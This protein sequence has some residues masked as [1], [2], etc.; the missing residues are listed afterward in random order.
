VRYDLGDPIFHTIADSRSIPGNDV[1]CI[2]EDRAGFLWIGTHDGAVRYDGYTFRLFRH[3]VH[4]PRSLLGNRIRAIRGGRD[5]RVWI[6][7]EDSGVSIFDPAKG[8]F[9]NLTARDSGLASDDIRDFA[10]GP[11]GQMWVSSTAGLDL[12]DEKTL[13]VSRV[14]PR[15]RGTD[16]AERGRPGPLLLD[17]RGDLWI[18]SAGGLAVRRRDGTI[19][20]AGKAAAGADSL[21][22]KPVYRLFEAKDGAIWIAVFGG[23]IARFDPLTGQVLF[24]DQG[25]PVRAYAFAQTEPATVWVGTSSD[26]IESRDAT[27][28][29]L[30]SRFTHD[31]SVPESIP[32]SRISSL[33]TD[34]SGIVWIGTTGSGLARY[35][36][37]DSAF[38]LL[39]YSPVRP[40]GLTNGEVECVFESSDGFL[41]V[42]THDT[43][44]DVFDS[45]RRVKGHRPGPDDGRSIDKARVGAITETP[46]GAIWMGTSGA[47]NRLD[48]KTGR[49]ERFAAEAFG[50]TTGRITTLVP[51]PDGQGIWTGSTSGLAFFDTR[52]HAAAPAEFEDGAKIT[53]TIFDIAL[54][55]GTLWAASAK[56]LAVLPRGAARFRLMNERQNTEGTFP[57][58]NPIDLLLDSKNKLWIGLASGLAR[59]SSFDGNTAR[60][61][62][63]APKLGL[64]N[65]RC[66][67]LLEDSSGRI[68]IEDDLMFDPETFVSRAFGPDEGAGRSIW[69]GAAIRT[70]SGQ[71]VLGSPDGLLFIDPSAVQNWTFA[72]PVV[73]TALRI[74]GKDLP[75]Q[76]LSPLVLSPGE[77]TVTFEFA[78]LDFSAPRRNRYSYRLRGFDR[79]WTNVD[80]DHRSATYTSLPPGELVFEVRGSNREGAWSN[81]MLSLPVEVKP[82]LYQLT[83]FRFAIGLLLIGLTWPLYRIRL[84]L[85]KKKQQELEALV[86]Q[87]TSELQHSEK[88]ARAASEAKSVF[89]ANMSHELRTPLNAVLGFTRLMRRSPSLGKADQEHLSIILRSGE[90]LLSLINQVLSISKIEAGKMTADTKPFD[91]RELLLTVERMF[92]ARAE[93][94]GLRFEVETKGLPPAVRGDAGK[95][96]QVLINLLGNAVKFT[97]AGRV[98]LRVHWKEER[99]S[100]EVEDTGHGI[101]EEELPALFTP[102]V[103]TESGRDAKEGT[104]L[105]LAITKRIVELMDGRIEVVSQ[106]GHGTTF[107]F[108]IALPQC[109][110]VPEERET[111][112]ILRI[113]GGKLP[114]R[115]AVVDDTP[116]NRFLLRDLLLTVGFD[117]Q[118]ATDGSEAL[119]LW[120]SWK[121]A[122][123]FM[124]VRMPV[125]DGHEATRRIREEEA[126]TSR[127]RTV[128]VALTAS[129]FESDQDT[130]TAAGVDD[131]LFKPYREEAIFDVIAVRLEVTFELEKAEAPSGEIRQ[132]DTVPSPPSPPRTP[133]ILITDDDPVNR[134]LASEVLK[135]AA[136]EVVEASDGEEAL[137]ILDSQGPF[138]AVLLDVQMPRLGGLATLE[139]LRSRY[140]RLPV[141]VMTAQDDPEEIGRLAVAGVDAYIS[142]P[143]EPA[144][145]TTKLAALTARSHVVIGPGHPALSEP[146]TSSTTVLAGIDTKSALRRFSG[147][148]RLLIQLVADFLSS[149][150]E[151]PELIRQAVEKHDFETAGRIA[152]A[153]KGAA[154]TLSATRIASAAR[155]IESAASTSGVTEEHIEELA[156][157]FSS[158]SAQPADRPVPGP[159]TPELETA[160]LGKLLAEL[161]GLVAENNLDAERVFTRVKGSLDARG[162]GEATRQLETHMKN[163]DFVAAG[164]VVEKI[165]RDLRLA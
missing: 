144:E 108:D 89:L 65:R 103:Q 48:R 22:G 136:Y 14:D 101:S 62:T 109:D 55:D 61:E 79:D 76:D 165:K 32:S 39:R 142:K 42:G 131:V 122:L 16:N 148:E 77:K 106:K 83:A 160:A 7:T 70:S 68:W 47:L 153:I 18:G 73:L 96:R 50:K 156:G 155:D 33:H 60:F 149:H 13:R 29:T 124:D 63:I 139:R 133:R 110:E 116:E 150:K 15:P 93:E 100:F 35:S 5:G 107:R 8:N 92:Q 23:G 105:G 138:A 141:I 12:V 40:G 104:G 143:F 56:G 125:M 157:A 152:H 37:A 121:P 114:P 120:R 44:T 51:T 9:V 115:I 134:A 95:L 52:T 132:T 49:I 119:S 94:A 123:I 90:H 67:N 27:S 53:G 41:W 1:S 158:C 45:S 117:V 31:A 135:E 78:S 111:A 130:L 54:Q 58:G 162:A 82:S 46:D 28:G 38:R 26:G 66:E 99:A 128:I 64:E 161:S 25:A 17:R 112:R 86:A 159:G 3:D 24:V 140:R 145:L 127:D 2:A 6:G 81:S 129:V 10:H 20:A 118:T 36:P 11:G 88:R 113:A 59:L 97:P 164:D 75:V 30:I 74:D 126:R 4:D 147:N 91:L 21:E 72:P 43:G 146:A 71:L 80:A 98:S 163:L 137:S 57:A 85:L 69:Q 34:R 102:F 87:R 154:A 151:T 19:E 84:R